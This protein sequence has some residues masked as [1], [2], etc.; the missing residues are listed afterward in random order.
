MKFTVTRE[1]LLKPLQWVSGVVER[2]QTQPILANLLIVLDDDVLSLTGTDSE[3]EIVSKL[4]MSFA[5]ENESGSITVPARKLF[6]ICRSLSPDQQILFVLEEQKLVI[7]SGRSRFALST[8][9][10]ADFPTTATEVSDVTFSVPKSAIK[11]LINATAFAMAQQDARYFLNGMLWEING[12][13]LRCVA[14]DGHRLALCSTSLDSSHANKFQVILPRKGVIEL[15]R[16]LDS[17]ATETICFSLD[18]RYF[19]AE[20]EEYTF[21]SKVVD[22][23]FPDYERVIPK[24]GENV[25][26]GNKN[27]LKQAFARMAILSSEKNLGVRLT[28]TRHLLTIVANNLEQ[29]EAEEKVNIEYNDNDVDIG[30][31]VSYLQDIANAI[32]HDSISIILSDNN[33]SAL[34]KDPDCSDVLYVI[35]PMRL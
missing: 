16:L 1:A 9:P 4:T 27:A 30:F 18:S 8:L 3:I 34:I 10:A 21:T 5:P 26:V 35:M 33:N 2:R 12:D 29:E 28:F 17:T 25:A 19:C 15:S 24:N 13:K 32:N 31:N 11:Q 20:T 23:K 22:G 7:N 6:D 14:T